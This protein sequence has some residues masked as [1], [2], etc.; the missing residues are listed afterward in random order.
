MTEDNVSVRNPKNAARWVFLGMV[1]LVVAGGVAYWLLRNPVP[2]PSPEEA[3]DPLLMEGRTVYFAR[4]APCHG[5][6]G[7]GDG[8]VASSLFGPPVANLSDGKWKHGGQP[9]DVVRLITQG[10][11]GTR[12]ASWGPELTPSQIR[13][14]AAY[15]FYLARER[16]PATLREAGP[17][18]PEVRLGH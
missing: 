8:P 15:A 10:V 12:M 17:P 4:C 13:A 11:A 6:E 9:E 3:A 18:V 14:V 7:R 16:V 5:P 1:G 2:P